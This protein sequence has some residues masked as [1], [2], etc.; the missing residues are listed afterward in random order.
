MTN[1]LRAETNASPAYNLP[2]SRP[3]A[4]IDRLATEALPCV[5]LI[6]DDDNY[7]EAL[8]G[9]LLDS[10]FDVTDFPGGREGLDYLSRGNRSDIILLDWK[11]PNMSGLDVLRQL[12]RRNVRTPVIFLTGM[13]SEEVEASARADGAVDFI[14]K[15]R[16]VSILTLRMRL[17]IHSSRAA[18]EGSPGEEVFNGRLRL[19]PSVCSTLWDGKPVELTVTE[20]RII[21]LLVRRSGDNVS[22]REIYDCVHGAGFIA[23]YGDDGFRT[24][25]RS[26]IKRI[27]QKFRAIDP[28]FAQIENLPSFGYRWRDAPYNGAS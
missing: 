20:F 28:D 4:G 18:G 19:K 22:Y 13:P 11:M 25:V 6:D 8:K 2:S 15:S 10:G 14:D 7:R 26:L 23:G 12:K 9:E 24:N 17:A 1:L 5:L 27:R 21:R 3:G 16:A